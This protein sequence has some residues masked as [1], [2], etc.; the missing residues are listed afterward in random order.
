MPKHLPRSLQPL[1]PLT[2]QQILA[3]SALM[4]VAALLFAFVLNLMAS[5]ICSTPCRSSS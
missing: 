3:R 4:L 5:A 1:A 2:A